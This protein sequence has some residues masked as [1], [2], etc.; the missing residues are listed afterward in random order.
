MI[1]LKEQY[2]KP[3]ET[4]LTQ[5]FYDWYY[6][7][8][9][10]LFESKRFNSIHNANNAL[11]AAIRR[12]K[13]VYLNGVFSGKFNAT[14]SRELS[15]FAKYDKRSKTWK[16]L[17]PS[18]VLGASVVANTRATQLNSE[19]KDLINKLDNNVQ[20][21]ISQ[22][23]LNIQPTIDAID[24]Q[25]TLDVKNITVL[26]EITPDMRDTIARNY[27]DNMKLNIVNEDGPGNWNAEQV[28]RLR[29][30]VE[31]NAMRGSNRIELRDMIQAEW[32]TTRAKAR[33]LARQ[34]TSLFLSEMRDTRFQ[35]AG[36]EKWRWS[37][38]GG[39]SGDGRTRDLHRELHGKV[40]TYSSPPIIDEKT[41]ER[42]MPGQAFGCRCM[43]IPIRD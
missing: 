30:M 37:A 11:I 32:N 9:L 6:R 34:E 15:R 8:I 21:V 27:T 7:P 12:G 25:L 42:G 28:T 23:S 35:G 26:P 4:D 39:K 14:I 31:K 22:L 29:D 1:K 13:I 16:G 19:L 3:I 17:P 43:L 33:F 2:Y 20:D 18:D 36:I 24:K 5:Y 41:G 38:T 10:K 40:F